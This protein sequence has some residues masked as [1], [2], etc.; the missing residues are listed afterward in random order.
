MSSCRARFAVRSGTH[1]EPTG[2]GENALYTDPR[3]LN[4]DG[5]ELA[6]IVNL[7]GMHLTEELEHSIDAAEAGSFWNSVGEMR[8]WI[9]ENDIRPAPRFEPDRLEFDN[10]EQAV[11]FKLRWF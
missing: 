4:T 11:T 6:S 2:Y 5:T 8:M 10:P 7:A 3:T 1:L 9:T